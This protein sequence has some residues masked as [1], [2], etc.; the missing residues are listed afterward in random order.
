[1]LRALNCPAE[2]YR[3]SSNVPFLCDKKYTFLRNLGTSL[4]CGITNAVPLAKKLERARVSVQDN[5]T[6]TGCIGIVFALRP[7]LAELPRG[8][9]AGF[10]LSNDRLSTVVNE[11]VPAFFLK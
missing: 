5:D 3:F 7:A 10:F 9:T 2:I 1:M 6:E 4:P 11:K 8:T